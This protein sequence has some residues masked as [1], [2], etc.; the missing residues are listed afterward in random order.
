MRLGLRSKLLIPTIGAVVISMCFS[1][2][3]WTDVG[4]NMSGF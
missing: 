4:T 2:S 1:G 3:S